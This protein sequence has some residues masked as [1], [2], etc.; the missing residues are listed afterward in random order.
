M[1]RKNF[2]SS[3]IIIV[4]CTGAIAQMPIVDF[5]YE[6][7]PGKD[8]LVKHKIELPVKPFQGYG[9]E[10]TPTFNDS[11]IRFDMPI[12]KEDTVK[13]GRFSLQIFPTIEKAQLELLN[14]LFAI[15]SN[16]KPPRLE[17]EKFPYGDV[18]FG[19]EKEGTLRVYFCKNNVFI[20]IATTTVFAKE[21]AAKTD[22]IIQA[23]PDW[24]SGYSKPAF[25]ISEEF[26]NAFFVKT[27]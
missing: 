9:L 20:I 18:A 22:S 15:Q 27:P 8:R 11:M 24:S 7:W 23:A 3:I 5:K 21:L 14:H 4:F 19:W 12:S 13:V 16:I 25:I 10:L 26:I 2:I 1:K 6:E 17:K